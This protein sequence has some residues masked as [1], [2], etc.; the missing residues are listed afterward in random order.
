MRQECSVRPIELPGTA[1]LT[2]SKFRRTAPEHDG[3]IVEIVYS[4]FVIGGVNGSRQI[5]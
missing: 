2:L 5:I 4:S 3:G 1:P